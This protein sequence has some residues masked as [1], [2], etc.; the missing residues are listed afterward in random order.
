MGHLAAK[1]RVQLG[2]DRPRV[3]NPIEEPHGRA[4]SEHLERGDRIAGLLPELRQ[5]GGVGQLRLAGE[6]GQRPLDAPLPAVCN[7]ESPRLGV[8]SRRE[9]RGR[10]EPFALGR[11][12][13]HV[14]R[15]C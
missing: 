7:R 8:V 6:R 5:D 13:L 1:A 4:V 10:P 9:G 2:V 15:E 12:T 11:R 14:P 3:D